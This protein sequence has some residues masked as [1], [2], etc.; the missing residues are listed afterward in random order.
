MNGKGKNSEMAGFMID[1]LFNKA[2]R[3]TN[4]SKTRTWAVKRLLTLKEVTMNLKLTKSKPSFFTV[5]LAI[6]GLLVMPVGGLQLF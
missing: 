4:E 5:G 1:V 2:W 3:E 6:L